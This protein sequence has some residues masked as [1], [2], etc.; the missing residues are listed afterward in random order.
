MKNNK[1]KI[2]VL[3]DLKGSTNSLIESTL[4]LAKMIDGEVNLFYVKKPTEVVDRENQLS[5]FRS[6]NQKYK[7]TKKK[8]ERI[9]ESYSKSHDITINYSYT[10]GNVRNEIENYIT[11]L[12]PDII[13]LGKRQSKSIRLMGDNLTD[14]VLKKHKGVIMIAGKENTLK[15]NQELSLG[16][17]NSKNPAIDMKLA[18]SL[19]AN[20]QKPLKTFKFSSKTEELEDVKPT[21]DVKTIDYVFEQNDNRINNLSS[22]LSKNKDNLLFVDRVNHSKN[23]IKSDFKELI[24]KLNVSLLFSSE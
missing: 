2:L 8:I 13:V 3:S 19:L 17:L 24:N 7:I 14:F 9:I 21:S 23:K 10:I 15:F 6:I 22:Y 4:S 1:Y 20:T 11:N 16:I 12:N 5:A 18:K